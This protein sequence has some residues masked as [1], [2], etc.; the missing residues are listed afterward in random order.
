MTVLLV[1]SLSQLY[2]SQPNASHGVC[3]PLKKAFFPPWAC[4]PLT[5]GSFG[6]E[7]KLQHLIFKAPVIMYGFR[8]KGYLQPLCHLQ[9]GA[10][11]FEGY[12]HTHDYLLASCSPPTYPACPQLQSR[13]E[14]GQDGGWEDGPSGELWKELQ[15]LVL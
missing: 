9:N 1:S 3:S 15:N 8:A 10:L 13:R 6:R 7:G 5:S 14:A 4:C 11:A 12:N 2:D